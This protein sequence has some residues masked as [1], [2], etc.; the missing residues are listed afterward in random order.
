MRG[1]WVALFVDAS[2]DYTC[3]C[4]W[5]C[6]A[7]LYVSSTFVCMCHFPRIKRQAGN[8]IDIGFRRSLFHSHQWDKK[9]T[10][11]GR[12]EWRGSL[13]RLAGEEIAE[14]KY[15]GSM[16]IF[17]VHGFSR[18]RQ[19]WTQVRD[20]LPQSHSAGILFKQ[21]TQ[22][23]PSQRIWVPA[24]WAARGSYLDKYTTFENS[25]GTLSI[26]LKTLTLLHIRPITQE[27]S[28][29]LESDQESAFMLGLV[30]APNGDSEHVAKMSSWSRCTSHSPKNSQ[31]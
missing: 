27:E 28:T 12:G 22:Q 23:H 1:R 9:K 24:A 13:R 16:D 30:T 17:K 4:F 11:R 3:I 6:E 18:H 29:A 19:S 10:G 8:V 25:W 31:V 21:C 14:F 7:S 5:F 20:R 15:A 26:I 2:C